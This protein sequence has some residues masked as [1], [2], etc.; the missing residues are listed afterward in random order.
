MEFQ[1]HYTRAGTENIQNLQNLIN[2]AKTPPLESQDIRHGK[3]NT[4]VQSNSQHLGR[5]TSAH[6]V[7][8][9]NS[10]AFNIN[11]FIEDKKEGRSNSR[12]LKQINKLFANQVQELK[13]KAR[14]I[15]DTRESMENMSRVQKTRHNNQHDSN[16]PYNQFVNDQKLVI[17]Y[18]GIRVASTPELAM[19]SSDRS[20]SRRNHRGARNLHST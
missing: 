16:R 3:A 20:S 2:A 11:R 6:G 15:K 18:D 19:M 12:I 7:D 4:V 14:K 8:E 9:S 10:A 5:Q 1:T 13:F 17:N